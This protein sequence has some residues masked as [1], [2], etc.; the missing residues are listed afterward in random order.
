MK[1]ST[2]IAALG[3]AVAAAGIWAGTASAQDMSGAGQARAALMK[4]QAGDLG[5]IHNF[6]IGKA[7]KAKAVAAAADLTDTTRKIPSV[8][9]EGSGGVNPS[10]KFVTKPEVWTDWS[11]FL[12]A[13]N[14]A[15]QKSYALEAAVKTGNKKKIQ[16]AFADLGKTGCGGCHGKFRANK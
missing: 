8:F 12:A 11:G 10:G 5:V 6:L 13:Q 9:P 15:V 4:Q 2:L 3:V 1:S 16:E 7:P 14:N